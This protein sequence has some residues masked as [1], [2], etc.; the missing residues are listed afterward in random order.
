MIEKKRPRVLNSSK[1]SRVRGP[2]EMYDA[3]NISASSDYGEDDEGGNM[4]VIKAAY[5]NSALSMFEDIVQTQ[6]R[7]RVIGSVLDDQNNVI[8]Y[9]VWSALAK[10]QGVWAY[11]PDMFLPGNTPVKKIYNSSLFKFP[12][13][14]FVKADVVVLSKNHTIGGIDY[15]V[16]P[17][18]YFT[19]GVNEPRQINILRA[20][21]NIRNP[22]KCYIPD[23]IAPSMMGL[24]EDYLINSESDF[25]IPINQR[26]E[27]FDTQDFIHASPKT[28][29][30]PIKGFFE[31]DPD[32]RVSNFEGISGMQFAYQYLYD[33]GEEAALST[34]SDIIVPPAYIQQGARASADLTT[35]NVLKLRIPIA[36]GVFD[37]AWVADNGIP[38][39]EEELIAYLA[40]GFNDGTINTG[41]LLEILAS[42]AD[43]DAEVVFPSDYLVRYAPKNVNKIRILMREG[44]RGM[45]SEVDTIVNTKAAVFNLDDD[46]NCFIN[47]DFRNDRVKK[48]FSKEEA[49]KPFDATPRVAGAQA[50]ASNRIMYG[51]YLAGYDNVDVEAVATVTYE[52]RPEDFKTLDI[53]IRPT[54]DLLNQDSSSVNN[55]RAG[56]YFDVDDFPHESIGLSDN[57]LI[58]IT[59]TLRPKRN[60]HIYNSHGAFHGSRHMGNLSA[61][62]IDPDPTN[63]DND[64]LPYQIS[65]NLAADGLNGVGPVEGE[66]GDFGTSKSR[67]TT[68]NNLGLDTMWGRNDGVGLAGT[69]RTVASQNSGT[70]STPEVPGVYGTSAAN[71]FILR[72]KPL[73]F[74]ISIKV[75]RNLAGPSYKARLRD[76]IQRS[77]T[78]A[79]F[80]GVFYDENGDTDYFETLN[81]INEF[82]YSIDEGLAGGDSSTTSAEAE[83]G[84]HIINVA[85]NGDDRKHL[86]VAVGNGNIVNSNASSMDLSNVAPCGYFIVNKARPTFSLRSR[87]DVEADHTYG[88][89]QLDLISLTD[90]ETQTCIPFMDG[91][92]W[93]DKAFRTDPLNTKK[94]GPE[95]TINWYNQGVG[96]FNEEKNWGLRDTTIWQ[97]QTLVIDSWYCYSKEFMFRNDVPKFLFTEIATD[98]PRY[99]NGPAKITDEMEAELNPEGTSAEDGGVVAGEVY[100]AFNILSSSVTNNGVLKNTAVLDYQYINL[101]LQEQSNGMGGIGNTE[102]QG[103]VTNVVYPQAHRLHFRHN[104]RVSVGGDG[105]LPCVIGWA[106]HHVNDGAN[107]YVNNRSRIVGWLDT[108]NSWFSDLDENLYDT[109]GIDGSDSYPYV[110]TLSS[111]NRGFTI[112]DGAGGIGGAPDG[113]EAR[114]KYDKGSTL[115]MGTVNGMM[116]FM[117][118]IGP[119]DTVLPTKIKDGSKPNLDFDTP[120]N[121]SHFYLHDRYDA[122]FNFFGQDCMMPFLGQFNYIRLSEYSGTRMGYRWNVVSPFGADFPIPPSFP[123]PSHFQ[124]GMSALYTATPLDPDITVPNGGQNI[125]SS[126]DAQN[127]NHDW[128]ID[129]E[130]HL[131]L[132]APAP[133]LIDVGG[134]TILAE[135]IRSGGRS[136]KTRANHAFGIVFY[137]ERGRAGKVNPLKY[138]DD[139][140]QDLGTSVY[141]QGYDERSNRGRAVVNLDL[142]ADIPDWA[143][144]YQVVY[145]GNVTKSRFIQYSTGGAC[146]ST[147]NDLEA[148]EASTNIYVSLNYLQ[149]N[150]DVS[151]SESFG[152]VTPQGAKQLYTHKPG[153]KLRIISYY[154][155]FD[156]DTSGLPNNGERIFPTDYEFEIVAVENLSKFAVDNPLRRAF[157]DSEESEIMS[158]FKSG[159]FLV[160]KNNPF[161]SGFT[162]SDVKNGGNRRSTNQH[163]WNNICVVEIYS[164]T[165]EAAEDEERLYYETSRVYDI[166]KNTEGRYFKTNPLKMERGDVWFRRVPLAVPEFVENEDSE[167]FNT[168]GNLIKYTKDN[169]E[170][171]STPRFQNYYLETR[172]FNDTFADNDSISRGKPN[173]IDVDFGEKQNKAS[174]IYSDKHIFNKTKN[175][176]SSFNAVRGNFKDLPGEFGRIEALVNNSDSL[177]V[178]QEN[179]TSSVPVERSI[180]STADGSNSLTQNTEVIGIQAFFAGDYGISGNPESVLKVGGFIYFASQDNKEVYRLSSGGIEV[181]SSIGMKSAFYDAFDAAINS[182]VKVYVPTGYDPLNDEFLITI[183]TLSH[184]PVQGTVLDVVDIGDPIADPGEDIF[185]GAEEAIEGC[186][187][188]SAGNFDNDATI[189][190]GSC[191]YL[192]C[193]QPGAINYNP[194]ATHECDNNDPNTFTAVLEPVT[195]DPYDAANYEDCVCRYFQPCILDAFSIV[196]DGIFTFNDAVDLYDFLFAGEGAVPPETP[197]QIY[198][199]SEGSPLLAGGAINSI[200]L[201][202]VWVIE[203]GYELPP[204]ELNGGNEWVFEEDTF[205]QS[206]FNYLVAVYTEGPNGY[207]GDTPEPG[208]AGPAF[209]GSFVSALYDIW[210]EAVTGFESGTGPGFFDQEEG[211]DVWYDDNTPVFTING[212]PWHSQ[213]SYSLYTGGVDCVYVGCTDPTA[214]NY[215]PAA[216]E[217]CQPVMGAR[218][219]DDEGEGFLC[220]DGSPPPCC[221]EGQIGT[222]PD[223]ECL[224]PDSLTVIYCL[225]DTVGAEE[226]P[227]LGLTN[228][229]I[230]IAIGTPGGVPD[231][232]PHNGEVFT[233]ASATELNTLVNW[234]G[235]QQSPNG[236]DY[237][238]TLQESEDCFECVDAGYEPPEGSTY[239]Y[240]EDCCIYICPPDPANSGIPHCIDGTYNADDW[241]PDNPNPNYDYNPN[242]DGN[243]QPG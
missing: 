84:G 147:S 16:D 239:Y 46:G 159:Q 70:M 161:A 144:Y 198:G 193:M 236:C 174:I 85:T 169:D 139:E 50:S 44:N 15:D 74:S 150:K 14:G 36:K 211:G 81:V 166:G 142:I 52:S 63:G 26:Y 120:L 156:D 160:L 197:D 27:I 18:L 223:C 225:G 88:V 111:Y 215:D 238:I 19:D 31:N 234:L 34:Y 191:V 80:T 131:R 38:E 157:S 226:C 219:I 100:L 86:I 179:K 186:A 148:D 127:Q 58:D 77:L 96:G 243:Q 173:I 164:P 116:V 59:L 25:Y 213:S 129:L 130:D 132:K 51:D 42:F 10:E 204:I 112:L 163:Y 95:D 119:R 115:T 177:V 189:E 224:N 48:G 113:G 109:S 146:V 134:G 158:D 210:D 229:G 145:G 196:P 152:A 30:H 233:V 241:D 208:T 82:T 202:F 123:K 6:T 57:S 183:K 188:P 137:D 141:I 125:L 75:T 199:P 76:Y 60:W 5:G 92:L 110:P 126:E 107:N 13:N 47:Y 66:P 105:F 242:V 55:R 102:E 187:D 140:G 237:E 94:R 3:L 185:G 136:F 190:D 175:R 203:G 62:N 12:S 37:A 1:D 2:E 135:E 114:L 28:P 67:S 53:N 121:N 162:Y 117:G 32:S 56:I 122:Y 101:M 222:P 171:G 172:A 231:F 180:L 78:G 91:E 35:T 29:I 73:L 118:Y 106:Y 216:S 103:N 33:T 228:I 54:I 65:P 20:Y 201:D 192:G 124:E 230:N 45:F 11:D 69:W 104:R 8:Y 40:E 41:G 93:R 138:I 227:G 217:P 24:T 176:F 205:T 178:I 17:I 209:S 83:G 221:P 240:Y 232:L 168:F 4:G 165:K 22:S 212:E 206:A 194:Q 149:Q 61:A 99:L 21:E 154:T 98:Y 155:S 235:N 97:F 7:R 200:G 207:Y 72:G 108:G 214:L 43:G 23:T 49:K 220:T 133:E 182:G 9:F 181:I 184:I 64:I 170:Q 71:P 90:V 195:G 218:M 143:F 153:D 167:D 89:L 87:G 79:P 128:T 151:Y 39:T 68:M